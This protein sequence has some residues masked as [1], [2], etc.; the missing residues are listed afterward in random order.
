MAA[1]QVAEDDLT[2]ALAMAGV[3]GVVAEV[4]GAVEVAGNVSDRWPPE[5]KN[6][7]ATR[8]GQV[9]LR[10]VAPILTSNLPFVLAPMNE[11]LC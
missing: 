7:G 3:G 10:R 9:T 5:Q 8:T 2:I 1:A 4:E 6:V 11:H